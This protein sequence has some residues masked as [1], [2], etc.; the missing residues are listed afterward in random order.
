[1]IAN[2]RCRVLLVEDDAAILEMTCDILK[3]DGF[4]VVPAADAEVAL[5][6]LECDGPFDLL[7]S[8]IGLPG[9]NGRDLAARVSALHPSMPILL[10][11]GYAGVAGARPGF[12]GTRMKLLR[13]PF[14][15]QQL[16][17]SVHELV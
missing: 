16:L 8:D 6:R 2:N 13:K 14:T 17:C 11:T 1:M 4:D 5:Q 9:M 7:F 15:L 10:M 3:G 12:P